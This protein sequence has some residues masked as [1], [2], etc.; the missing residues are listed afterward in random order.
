MRAAAARRARGTRARAH[1][2]HAAAV[3][4]AATCLQ[5]HPL[6]R[7]MAPARLATSYSKASARPQQGRRPAAQALTRAAA[8]PGLLQ[9]RFMVTL[10]L[11]C[12]DTLYSNE[13]QVAGR[14]TAKIGEYC[15]DKLGLSDG[16]SYELYKAHGTC[17]R[18]L[19]KEGIE[20]DRAD[21]LK[22]VHDIELADVIQPEP[23]LAALLQRID[24]SKCSPWVYTASVEHHAQNCLNCLGISD[25]L[26]NRP[27]IDV[28][29]VGFLTKYPSPNVL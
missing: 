11:D 9:P 18:G 14:I 20:H 5:L 24:P 15:K 19:E 23:E 22:T 2:G 3:M 7:C 26:P 28:A 1:A 16:K 4:A 21:F 8:D 27:I 29:A 25:A 17:L 12:D 6:T 10:F 13:W